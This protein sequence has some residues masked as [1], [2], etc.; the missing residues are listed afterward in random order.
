VKEQRPR[1]TQQAEPKESD[2]EREAR[3]LEDQAK[4][5]ADMELEVCTAC[6]LLFFGFFFIYF[7][8]CFL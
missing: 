2:V 8:S 4:G 6:G 5:R 1:V 3:L 7:P